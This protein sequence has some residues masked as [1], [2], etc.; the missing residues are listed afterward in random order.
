MSEN[1]PDFEK[2]A[3]QLARPSGAEG[4]D[5]GNRMN[6]SNGEMTLHAID[7]LNIN[8]GDR[9]LELGPGNAKFASY[10]LEK[11]KDVRYFGGDISALMIDEAKKNN[12]SYCE[13]G[14]ASFHLLD[15]FSLPFESQFFHKILTVNTLYF[16]GNPTQQL[17]E[18]YRVL[19]PAGALCIAIRSRGFMETLPFTKYGFTLYSPEEGVALFEQS[20]FQDISY[21]VIS[22]KGETFTGEP[23]VKEDVFFILRK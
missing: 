7:L 9:V 10:V 19:K 13:A 2:I 3:A 4:I 23:V 16:W 22:T 18:L 5:V 14:M 6:E 1:T 12:Q 21:T 17:E 8:N 15:G 20:P 11:A